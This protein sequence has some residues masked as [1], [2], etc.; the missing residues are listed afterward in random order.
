[1]TFGRPLTAVIEESIG[2][3]GVVRIITHSVNQWVRELGNQ[4]RY[5]PAHY[6]DTFNNHSVT[7]P[8]AKDLSHPKTLSERLMQP[9]WSELIVQ[10]GGVDIKQSNV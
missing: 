5:A 7:S 2:K 6:F 9:D 1:M 3:E 8:A 10:L 4:Y